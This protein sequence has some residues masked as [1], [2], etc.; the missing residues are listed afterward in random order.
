MPCCAESHVWLVGW[1][2]YLDL[3]CLVYL[4]DTEV[5]E[6]LLLLVYRILSYFLCLQVS[7]S[8]LSPSPTPSFFLCSFTFFTPSFI[9]SFLSFPLS[10]PHFLQDLLF[11]C[12]PGITQIHLGRNNFST[13]PIT[14]PSHL[15]RINVCMYCSTTV[16]IQYTPY[17][18]LAG[19]PHSC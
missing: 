10:L 7:F 3:I 16:Q 11:G 12:T 15:A 9:A 18:I 13:F 1:L 14:D 2:A 5:G 19:T 6:Y 8:V 4:G 17:T